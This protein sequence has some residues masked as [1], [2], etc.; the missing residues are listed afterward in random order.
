MREEGGIKY[1]RMPFILRGLIRS[2]FIRNIVDIFTSNVMIEKTLLRREGLGGLGKEGR[3][4]DGGWHATEDELL[5]VDGM[6]GGGGASDGIVRSF[7][8]I[9]SIVDMCR[10]GCCEQGWNEKARCL[11]DKSA[12]KRAVAKY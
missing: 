10:W 9:T 6:G 4:G 2:P 12:M 7:V 5:E 11:R 8:N 3:G 1:G